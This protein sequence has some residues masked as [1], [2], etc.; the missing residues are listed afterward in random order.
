MKFLEVS[1]SWKQGLKQVFDENSEKRMA[2]MRLLKFDWMK[3]HK[4]YTDLKNGPESWEKLWN[5][6]KLWKF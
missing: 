3:I 2:P 1:E 4:I 6:R 5:Q